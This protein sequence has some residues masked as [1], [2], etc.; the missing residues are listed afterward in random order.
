MP[1]L[2]IR[3]EISD[4]HRCPECRR[5]WECCPSCFSWPLPFAH[6]NHQSG[7]PDYGLDCDGKTVL[8]LPND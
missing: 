8:R 4:R 3:D 5:C 6:W 7:C 1:A 2:M